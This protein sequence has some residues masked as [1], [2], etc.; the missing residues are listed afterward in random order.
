[1]NTSMSSKKLFLCG[2]LLLNATAVAAQEPVDICPDAAS[3]ASINVLLTSLLKS[4]QAQDN[5]G[6]GFHMWASVVN[7]AGQVCAIA[8]SGDN[9]DSQWPGSRVIAA[10]K[11]NTANA[12]SLPGFALS[13]A[14]LHD[15]TQNG[16]S[17]F[18]LQFSNP[19][20][21]SVAYAGNASDYGT[22][23]DAMLGKKIGGINVFGGGLALYASN[24]DLLGA[25]GVSGDSSC[26]DHNIAW[27][28]RSA[29]QLDFVPAGPSPTGNDQIIYTGETGKG[30]KGFEHTDCGHT[31]KTVA[32]SLAPTRKQI[33]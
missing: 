31:E 25:V 3:K 5:G 4:A 27:R 19:V 2:V 10:Q 17:L 23:N 18:G 28:I 7:R 30:S 14:N 22:V 16:G 24:G 33:K 8:R 13:T 32:S 21:T 12:F 20:D 6:F 11:A 26:A 9:S 1:M 29:A 15:A